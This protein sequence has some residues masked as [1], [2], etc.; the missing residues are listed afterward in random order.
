MYYSVSGAWVDM[1]RALIPW[2]STST[3]RFLGLP[4]F[5][6][7][8]WT[9]KRPMGENS[10]VNYEALRALYRN[11]GDNGLG[12]GFAKPII[13]IPVNFIGMPVISAD[14][15]A[16]SD[17][18][19]EC[20]RTYW[21]NEIKQMLRDS[22]RDSK[23]IVRL[24]RP[25]IFDPLMT[26]EE[27]D[28]CALEMFPPELVQIERH[29]ENKWI[30]QRAVIHHRMLFIKDEGDIAQGRDPI[31]EEHEVLEF[32]TRDDFKFF[33]NTTSEWLTDMEAVNRYGFVP[34]VEVY[35]EY[36]STLKGGQSDLETVIPF[37]Q[38]FHDAL[39]QGLQAHGYHSTPK[40]M[41]KLTDVA[42]FIM[43]NFPEAVDTETGQIKQDGE[44][45][46]RGREILFVQTDEDISF[47]EAKSVLGDT[48][49]LLEFLIDCICIASQTP[50]WAFMRVDSG[51]AN[52]D[53]NAQTVPLLKKIEGKRIN[54]TDPIQQLCKMVLVMNGLIPV[55]PEISWQIIR[56]DDE[57]VF[58]QAFQ[59]LVMGLEVAA[60]RGEISDETYRR[61]LKQFLPVMKS[62]V[63]EGKQ[64]QLDMQRQAQQQAQLNPAPGPNQQ[65]GGQ[66]SKYNYY[67]H[68]GGGT[69]VAQGGQQ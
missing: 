21:A 66:G 57:V 40:V 26:I 27:S 36:D 44:I 9:T 53:R 60:Q 24:R 28:H 29:P 41:M 19:N 54:F 31:V 13:D 32:I 52:S 7:R 18:L 1:T 10:I 63:D 14:N 61:M 62:S 69:P 16:T 65:G 51:S 23:V 56:V 49:V 35:N 5:G 17:F 15:E 48:H 12:A 22:M 50:E 8:F 42:P 64:A 58:Y 33:D 20:I 37:I 11:S 47:L 59:Q 43:N 3:L 4:N 38:A 25:D 2:S 67:Y 30:I 68:Q 46:W 6:L 39:T 55:R 45:S 34:L